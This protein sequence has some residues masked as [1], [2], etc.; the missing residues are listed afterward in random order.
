MNL[1]TSKYGV[2]IFILKS[3]M[4]S[5]LKV[6]FM[7]NIYT[8]IYTSTLFDK[9]VLW[10]KE[11]PTLWFIIS[12]LKSNKLLYVLLHKEILLLYPYCVIHIS[13]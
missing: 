10:I 8:M 13:Y 4:Y 12:S 9:S 6:E 7:L 1:N 2:L 11:K 5:I 3:N